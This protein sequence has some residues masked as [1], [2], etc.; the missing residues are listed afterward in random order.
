M[1]A[2]LSVASVQETVT[3][4][5]EAPS[6]LETTQ[7]GATLTAR[8]VDT[9]ATGRTLEQIADLAPGLTDNTPNAGR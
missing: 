3:V 2:T 8:D 1:N 4:T 5:G 9:L 6:A 7:T